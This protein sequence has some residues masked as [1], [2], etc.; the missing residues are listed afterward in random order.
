MSNGK[1]MLELEERGYV[2][3]ND[4]ERR[5]ERRAEKEVRAIESQ[6]LREPWWTYQ[7]RD[8]R[9]IKEKEGK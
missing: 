8:E 7:D 9:W 5:Y 1:H 3:Y 6:K 2:T 4:E